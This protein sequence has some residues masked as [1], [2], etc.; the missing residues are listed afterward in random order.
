VHNWING[1]AMAPHH[2]ERL[3]G[4]LLLIN[5]LAA[6]TPTERRAALLD[7]TD[8]PS[9]FHQL[10]RENPRGEPLQVEAISLRDRL[11]G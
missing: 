10:V 11:E 4:I 5:D 9:L 7:S 8:G 2:E 3:A 6:S 1:S